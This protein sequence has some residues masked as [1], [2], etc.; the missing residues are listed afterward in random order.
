MM[1]GKITCFGYPSLSEFKIK[2]VMLPQMQ[3][4][5]VGGLRYMLM[6]YFLNFRLLQHGCKIKK[7]FRYLKPLWVN[8]L[9]IDY[10]TTAAES[11][12]V[13]S[14]TAAAAAAAASTAAIESA[15]LVESAL[16]LAAASSLLPPQATIATAKPHTIRDA[17]NF[18]IVYRLFEFERKDMNS[19]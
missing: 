5:G 12:A 3:A 13:V 7:G 11:T 1:A 6:K 9:K 4:V 14:A 16:A 10:L 17:I 2:R 19:V 15:T 18:F 8:L